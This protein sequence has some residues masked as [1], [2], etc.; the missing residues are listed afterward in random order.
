VY[1]FIILLFFYT[2]SVLADNT[3]EPAISVGVGYSD[4]VDQDAENEKTSSIAEVSPSLRF[5]KEGARIKTNLDYT[6]NAY[7]YSNGS[8]EDKNNTRHDLQANMQAELLQKNFF[9]DLDASITQEQLNKRQGD[10][11]DSQTGIDNLTETYTYGI[12]P[13]WKQHWSSYADSIVSYEFN[14]VSF[15]DTNNNGNANILSNDSSENK[16][17]MTVTNG[18]KFRNIVW[19]LDF[20]Y[21]KVDYKDTLI[22]SKD[23]ESKIYLA[24]LGYQLNNEFLLISKFGYEE[25]E[26]T[27]DFPSTDNSGSFSGLGFVWSPSSRTHLEF[28]FGDRFYGDAYDLIFEHQGDALGFNFSYNESVT[29]ARDEYRENNSNTQDQFF[30]TQNQLFN[31][32][33]AAATGTTTSSINQTL[34]SL[35]FSKSYNAAINYQLKKIALHL[36]AYHDDRD[37]GQGKQLLNETVYGADFS[38]TYQDK[39]SIYKLGSHFEERDSNQLTQQG[40]DY[41]VDLSWDFKIGKRMNSITSLSL[42]NQQYDGENDNSSDELLFSW[43]LNRQLSRDLSGSI[44]LSH[45]ERTSDADIKLDEFTENSFFVNLN[46][47]FR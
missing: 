12:N 23:S 5:T 16:V 36:G 4:N 25:Y 17:K 32:K 19:K 45:Q 28:T 30:N 11:A 37:Y 18:K 15:N 10:I 2:G 24:E 27:T 43:E 7:A 14:E 9:I 21:S 39:K 26:Q 35:Y 20:D 40:T 38:I 42:L 3:F 29:G 41:G 22:D 33:Y 47:T 13:Y 44:R 31:D 8:V 1:I 46:K 34:D 6:L